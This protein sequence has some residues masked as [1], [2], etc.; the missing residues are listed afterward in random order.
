MTDASTKDKEHARLVLVTG[1]SGAGRS[2]ALKAL[3]D[4][5]FEAID[6]MPISL[7]RPLVAAP[8]AR[9]LALVLDPRNRDFSVDA[10]LALVDDL[11]ALRRM[12][13]DLVFLD[14]PIP[15]LIR[16]FSETRRR[17]PLS[18]DGTAREGIEFEA[19]LLAPVRLRADVLIETETLTPRDLRARVHGLFDESAGSSMRVQVE[20]FSY[21]RGIPAGV[22][23]VFDCRFLKNPHWEI[24]LRR[25]DGRDT[26]VACFVMA[27]HRFDGFF[28]RIHE[29]VESLLPEYAHEGKSQLTIG[30]GCTG[31]QHRSVATAEKLA[32]ALAHTQWQ[33]SKRH[34]ELERI[35]TQVAS[36]ENE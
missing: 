2:T 26:R 9:P 18:P 30:F 5:G 4:I 13:L 12:T 24:E 14:C 35:A 3:E 22:D 8:L 19:R 31:G 21:K 36:A 15:V 33:V 25:L 6:N 10:L 16:R 17:H 29:L 27:D 20:S 32:N 7:V 34:R 11:E 23:L 28:R 1:P